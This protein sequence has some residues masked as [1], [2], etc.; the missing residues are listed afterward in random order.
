MTRRSRSTSARLSLV[1]VTAAVTLSAAGAEAQPFTSL[2]IF[3]DSYSDTGNA[4]ILSAAFGYPNPTPPP[5]FPGHFS[6]GPVWV[7]YLATALGRP[8]VSVVPVAL[9]GTV[10]AG[11]GA[12][13]GV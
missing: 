6:N 9:A 4:S 8:A 11:V 1:A 2:T 5:F 13:E 3:G 10:G 12:A 7:E